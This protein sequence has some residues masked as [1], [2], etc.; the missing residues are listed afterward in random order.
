MVRF[1]RTDFLASFRSKF[2]L[3]LALAWLTGLLF[4]VYIACSSNHSIYLV[5]RSAPESAVSIVGLLAAMLLPLLLTA[6]AVY[7]SKI[8]FVIPVAFC[9]AFLFAYLSVAALC[10]RIAG[11]WLL[12]LL[13]LFG[14]ILSAPVY[15]RLWMR[16]PDN[17][18]KFALFASSLA[19]IVVIGFLDFHYIS[20]FLAKILI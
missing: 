5:M 8:Q 9:K 18:P 3:H 1:F 16:I 20:P 13:L 2:L 17:K 6:L 14:D 12:W 10:C 11:G 4:G 7:I 15:L 19:A